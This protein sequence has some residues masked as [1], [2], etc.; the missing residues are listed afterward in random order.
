MSKEKIQ[1]TKFT[2]GGGCGCK[3]SPEVLSEIL[4]NKP[5]GQQ[6]P[7]LLVGNEHADDAAVFKINNSQCLISTTDFFMPVVDDARTFGKIAAA[8]A[9]SDVWAMGGS[10]V[11]ALAILGWPVEK[12]PASLAAEVMEGALDICNQAGIPVAGGH[13]IDSPEPF[14][15]LS[16]NGL[17]EEKNLKQNHSA[18]AGDLIYLTKP[19]GFGILTTAKKRELITVNELQEAIDWMTKP[20]SIGKIFGGQNFIHAMTDVTGFGLLGHLL[21]MATG[22]GLSVEIDYAK[23]NFL[24]GVRNLAAKMIY[25]DATMRNW[26]S[27]E[28]QVEGISAESLVTLCDPQTSGGLLVAVSP[29]AK[30]DFENLLTESG[31]AAFISPFGRFIKKENA[32]LRIRY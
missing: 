13:S 27:F 17:V 9:L 11:M 7:N 23:I 32:A 31:L 21:E 18:K 4:K 16:V 6:F 5:T 29:D 8:N 30:S 28:K 2:K 24:T 20:N 15:G 19:L 26:K 14:F 3:I 1:L 10:P 25:P 22:S 12:L